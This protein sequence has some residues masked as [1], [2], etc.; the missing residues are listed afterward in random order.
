MTNVV[1]VSKHA[2]K[3]ETSEVVQL[4][5]SIVVGCLDE[6]L[7]GLS[8]QLVLIVHLD[9]SLQL[10]VVALLGPN[11]A[12]LDRLF[13]LLIGL[14]IVSLSLQV[15]LG[16]EHTY[17]IFLGQVAWSV[18][19]WLVRNES[20]RVR[21]FGAE[22]RGGNKLYNFKECLVNRTDEVLTGIDL[23]LES[24]SDYVDAGAERL[25]SLSVFVKFVFIGTEVGHMQFVLRDKH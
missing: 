19:T 24:L 14:L 25:G 9:A 21:R 7:L 1:Y 16:S 2:G 4:L 15:A 22:S 17:A 3:Q 18:G 8:G 6:H 11:M 20:V 5:V 13:L 10:F 12:I 23:G